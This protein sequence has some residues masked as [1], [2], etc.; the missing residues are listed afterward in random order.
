MSFKVPRVWMTPCTALLWGLAFGSACTREEPRLH[1]VSAIPATTTVGSAV[2]PSTT[3]GSAVPPSTTVGSAVPPRSRVASS[4]RDAGLA[5]SERTLRFAWSPPGAN[6]AAYRLDALE[7]QHQLVITAGVLEQSSVDVVIAMHG[8]PRPGELP[9]NYAFGRTVTGVVRTM[10]EEG[11]VEPMVLALPVFRFQGE[12]WPG[13]DLRAFIT[14]V[15]Q[16][17]AGEH[18]QTRRIRVFGHS[19]AAGC[20]GQGLNRA[21]EAPVTAVGFFDTCVGPGFVSAVKELEQRGI[22]T[23]VVHSVETAGFR[24][25]QPVE[26]LSTFDYGRVY[27]PLGLVPS[28]CP[29]ELPQAPLRSLDYRCASSA[30]GNVLALVLDTGEGEPAHQAVVPV[31]LRYFLEQYGKR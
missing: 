25:R 19:G 11:R 21:F 28:P 5:P 10:V 2:P 20:G 6:P 29:A 27:R 8:Q 30:T 22:A 17:L 26:Y 24:P 4:T 18:L 15:K 1:N 7:D 23:L 9:R 12:N 3:V 14:E 16:R 13:F 31:A